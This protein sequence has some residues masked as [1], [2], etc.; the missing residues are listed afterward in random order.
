MARGVK[1]AILFREK[2]NEYYHGHQVMRVK[3]C[4]IFSISGYIT[5][6]LIALRAKIFNC[7]QNMSQ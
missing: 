7:A 6:S 3:A 1:A 4:T 5:E 2:W